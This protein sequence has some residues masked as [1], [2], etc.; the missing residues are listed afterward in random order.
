[1]LHLFRRLGLA[2]FFA[3]LLI[4][5]IAPASYAASSLLPIHVSGNQIVRS[6]GHVIRLLGVNHSGTEAECDQGAN[7]PYGWGTF[8][9]ETDL[10]AAQSIASWHTN[11]VRIP[12]NED[13]WLGI[14]GVNPQYGG[15]TYRNAIVNYVNTL[16][17][18]NLYAII[19]L[20]WS[21]PG[22]YPAQA[23]NILPDADHAT[24]FWQSVA[25]TF[26]A[27]QAVVF[28]LF[29]EPT[30]PEGYMQR[31]TQDPWDCWLNGCPLTQFISGANR[32]TTAYTWQSIGMQMLVNAVRG[33]GAKNILLVGGLGYADDLSGWLPHAP[34]DP[35]QNMAASWHAYLMPPCYAMQCWDSQIAPIAQLYPVVIGETGDNICAPI[36]FVSWLLPW[37]DA[38]GISYLG[39]TWN[40]WAGSMHLCSNVLITDYSGSPTA[41]FGQYFHDHL[42]SLPLTGNRG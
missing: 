4:A 5:P 12:L 15:A 10:A 2:L 29:N 7:A 11:V 34:V 35:L 32:A 39:W 3:S 18:A 21:A 1:M 30:I 6:D 38:H 27:D 17:S 36:N 23:Q 13:C 28:D 19:D 42:M 24:A 16:H 33:T 20:H 25:T 37:A 9:G 8:D 26:Q 41:N 22:R 31:P 40:T 14:N